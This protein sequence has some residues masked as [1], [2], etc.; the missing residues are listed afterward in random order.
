[1]TDETQATPSPKREMTP[2]ALEAHAE[3][4]RRLAAHYMKALEEVI[5]SKGIDAASAIAARALGSNPEAPEQPQPFAWYWFDHLGSLYMTGNDR[6]PDVPGHAKPL[7]EHPAPPPPSLHVAGVKA[8]QIT[9]GRGLVDVTMITHE[10]RSGILFR[11][12]DHHIP[13]GEPGEIQAGEYWPVEGDVVIWIEN[14]GG[15][16]VVAK[17]LASVRAALAATEDSTDA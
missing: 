3:H 12:R 10:G 7:Y 13:V 11:P 9:M 6:K 2:R 4:M 17:G 14:E 16:E 5:L 1:M 8:A 15:A